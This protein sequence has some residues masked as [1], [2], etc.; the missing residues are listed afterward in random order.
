MEKRK[1]LVWNVNIWMSFLNYFENLNPT[2]WIISEMGSSLNANWIFNRNWFSFFGNDQLH[3]KKLLKI[4]AI[5]PNL[6]SWAHCARPLNCLPRY[7]CLKKWKKSDLHFFPHFW[8][9]FESETV[10]IA[11]IASEEMSRNPLIQTAICANK[12]KVENQNKS[13]KISH[14]SARNFMK[15]LLAPRWRNEKRQKILVFAVFRLCWRFGTFGELWLKRVRVSTRIGFL[16]EIGSVFSGMISFTKKL[17]KIR[18]I[19]AHEPIVL[20]RWIVC[21]VISVWRKWKKSDLHFFPHF[22]SAITNT[23]F[24]PVKSQK[25]AQNVQI[26]RE[27]NGKSSIYGVP[28]KGVWYME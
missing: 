5:S 1:S 4:R 24:L 22:G 10:V 21:R 26:A 7:F 11:S 17:L 2:G 13:R 28:K 8:F 20:A 9:A 27:R 14:V 23:Q 6:R 18:A 19:S 3:T 15:I 25:Y 12:V 16:T